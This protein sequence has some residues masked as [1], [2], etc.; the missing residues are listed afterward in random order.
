MKVGLVQP[1]ARKKKQEDSSRRL[2]M[3]FEPEARAGGGQ[4]DN[5]RAR[6]IDTYFV[7]DMLGRAK[8]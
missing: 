8:K 3:I 1:P 2:D 4:Y 6:N 7:R 5:K